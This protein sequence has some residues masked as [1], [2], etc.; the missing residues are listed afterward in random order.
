MVT[1]SGLIFIGATMDGLFRAFDIEDGKTLWEYELPTSAN[2]VPMSYTYNGEQY[3]I[4]AAGGHFTSPMP[5][6]DY[7]T[8]FKLP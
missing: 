8:A 6:G 4:V 5:A 7:V 2:T 1:K 3:V